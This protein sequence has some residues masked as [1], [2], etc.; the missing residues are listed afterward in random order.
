MN[1]SLLMLY[2]GRSHSTGLSYTMY[3]CCLCFVAIDEVMLVLHLCYEGISGVSPSTCKRVT[4]LYP[5]ADTADWL[6][7]LLYLMPK[8]FLFSVIIFIISNSMSRLCW[9]LNI[10]T[11]PLQYSLS[12]KTTIISVYRLFS[13]ILMSDSFP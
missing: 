2:L 9:F 8:L 1:I 5:K 10:M 13:L 6:I 7:F 4:R 12:L 11:K 3:C